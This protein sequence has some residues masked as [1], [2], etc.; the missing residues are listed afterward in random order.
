VILSSGYA[1]EE[2]RRN[3]DTDVARARLE[4]L[5]EKTQIVPEAPDASLPRGISL[6]EKDR[7]ILQAAIAAWATHLVTGDLRDFGPLLGK[8]VG[9]VRVQTPADLLRSRRPR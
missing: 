4:R 2:A 3:L 9:G 6:A 7:P 8:Q 1:A 5:L